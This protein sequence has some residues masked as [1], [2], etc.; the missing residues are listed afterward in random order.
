MRKRVSKW[1]RKK[2]KMVSLSSSVPPIQVFPISDAAPRTFSFTHPDVL[3]LELVRVGGVRE[4]V[5][6]AGEGQEQEGDE[7]LH[8]CER[9]EGVKRSFGRKKA[10][11]EEKAK[12]KSSDNFPPFFFPFEQF[13]AGLRRFLRP[14]RKVRL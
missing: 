3:A 10:A 5:G 7:E 12:K 11:E 1:S 14:N 9:V 13:Y 6:D 4:R 8:G 2:K